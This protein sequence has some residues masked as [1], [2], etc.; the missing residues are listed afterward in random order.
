V[1]VDPSFQ[2]LQLIEVR[3]RFDQEFSSPESVHDILNLVGLR[4]DEIHPLRI[5]LLHGFNCYSQNRK[6]RR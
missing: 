1:A 4:E 5:R 2:D 6:S 3:L